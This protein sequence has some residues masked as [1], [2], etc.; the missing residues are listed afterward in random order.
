MKPSDNPD[1]FRLPPPEGRSR[2]SRIV[3]RADGRFF[4]HGEEVSHP[5]L[6][7]A[8]HQWIGRHPESGRYI[9]QNGYDWTYFTVEDVPFFVDKVAWGPA[10]CLH[11]SD[12][13]REPWE[14]RNSYVLEHALYVW[15]KPA[16][17]GGPYPAKFS[18]LATLSLEGLLDFRGEQWGLLTEGVFVAFSGVPHAGDSDSVS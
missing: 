13:T 9:L 15:V 3:L 5:G 7:R 14:L 16:C 4:D 12:G 8:M 18:R 17:P 10:A 6:R 1:F 11:L 2:E